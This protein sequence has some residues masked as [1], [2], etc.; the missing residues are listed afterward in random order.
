MENNEFNNAVPE[1]TKGAKTDTSASIKLDTDEEASNH[2]RIAKNKL[3]NIS[4][5]HMY[6]GT[7]TADFQLTDNDGNAV[8]RLAQESDHFRINIPGPGSKTGDGFDW[9]Q[10][11]KIKEE[12]GMDSEQ[13]S[14]IVQ[15]ATNPNNASPDTAHF[16]KEDASSTFI[17]RREGKTVFAEV[18]GRNEQPNTEAESLI[19]KVR[20]VVVAAGAMFGFS[21]VQW[22]S[23]VEGFVD[24]KIT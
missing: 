4:R 24:Q 9:V 17:V 7:G 11:Q 12:T 19:D 3:L 2:Y 14:V 16:F 23:L 8:S 18:H 1:Q 21:K 20:N 6:A 5:W 10:I 13:I 22:K 15:P